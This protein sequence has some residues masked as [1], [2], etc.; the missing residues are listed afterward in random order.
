MSKDRKERPFEA[1]RLDVRA[2]AAA[3]AALQGTLPQAD[4]PR[5]AESTLALPGDG[6]LPPVAWSARG[7]QRPVTGGEPEVWLHLQAETAVWLQ[8]QR[9]LQP[10]HAPLAVA[11]WFRFVAT[12]EEAERLDEAS[13]DDVLV[14]PRSLDAQELLE[15]ELILAL[16]LVPRHDACPQPLPTSVGEEAIEDD[17]PNPFAALAALK[18]PPPGG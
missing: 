5:L 18:R 17:A 10:L 4:L 2:F 12:E 3:A 1:R 15:D 16:P 7:E 11:R 14:L 6:A 13:E 8:C 9:C